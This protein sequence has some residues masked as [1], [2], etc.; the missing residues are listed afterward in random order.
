[1]FSSEET[2]VYELFSMLS[3]NDGYLGVAQLVTTPMRGE[4]D[5]FARWQ[6]SVSV[7]GG[8]S[9]GQV[10][11]VPRLNEELA[12]NPERLLANWD[13]AVDGSVRKLLERKLVKSIRTWRPSVVVTEPSGTSSS[14]V[15]QLVQQ[16]VSSA[17]QRASDPTWYPEQLGEMG[18][19]SWQ[20]KRVFAVEMERRPAVRINTA[21]LAPRLGMSV[22]QH[23]SRAR[24]V[25]VREF[26]KMSQTI[27]FTLLT[28][29][30]RAIAQ[31]S[32]M[33]SGV[34]LAPGG[35]ARREVSVSA[36][37]DVDSLVR[38]SRQWRN[39]QQLVDRGL[40]ASAKR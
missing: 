4:G 12:V 26:E 21:Q 37:A 18:L 7:A 2:T 32:S 36:S 1:M 38:V 9:A 6:E 29:H 40:Q 17:V 31:G 10:F 35:E 27:G 28:S 13:R 39:M 8:S 22:S 16:V 34:Q 20:V 15:Q 33:M 24:A 19:E 23:A 11:T 14:A 5:M 25:T 30:D 3:G